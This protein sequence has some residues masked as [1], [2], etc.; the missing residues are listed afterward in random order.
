MLIRLQ[1]TFTTAD[2]CKCE[3]VTLSEEM[4]HEYAAAHISNRLSYS[5]EPVHNTLS[6]NRLAPGRDPCCYKPLLPGD[7]KPCV[8]APLTASSSLSIATIWGWGEATFLHVSC[9]WAVARNSRFQPE[10]FSH[11]RSPWH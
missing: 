6:R 9:P 7:A 3:Q 5:D 11:L 8:G 4:R 1:Y 2:T 10:R